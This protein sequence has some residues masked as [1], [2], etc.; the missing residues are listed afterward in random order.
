MGWKLRVAVVIA[1]LSAALPVTATDTVRRVTPLGHDSDDMHY[2]V[3]CRDRSVGS[4]IVRP[5]EDQTCA[6]TAAKTRRCE[7]DWSVSEAAQ[8]VCTPQPE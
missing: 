7:A 5:L 2:Q 3:T 6:A 8:Y 4:I 1:T